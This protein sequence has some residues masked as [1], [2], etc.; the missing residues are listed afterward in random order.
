[1]TRLRDR[2][3]ERWDSLAKSERAVS[4]VLTAMSAERIL[5]ASAAELGAQSKTSN[6]SVVRTLQTLGYAGLSE[7]KQEVAAPFSSTV[8]PEVRLRSRLEHLGQDLGQIQREIWSE[9]QDLVALASRA[10]TDAQ[11]SSAV[12]LVIHADTVFCYGLG[13][14]GIA[15]DHLALRLRRIGVST[16]RLTTDGFRLADEVMSLGSRDLLVIFAPGRVTRDIEALLD[17]AHLVGASVLLITD[18]LHE[19]LGSR[20][21]VSLAAPH[22]PTGLTAE[23][24]AGILTGDVLVQGVSAVGPDTALRSSQTLNDLRGRLGY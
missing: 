21:T 14:S 7:L 17:Q 18:E 6:A 13:A 12:N 22:T 3:S 19:Q 9:A 11:Y 2:I 8:S 1:M 23:G 10:N 4:R 16:R 15:A 24:I 5:Y 20:V